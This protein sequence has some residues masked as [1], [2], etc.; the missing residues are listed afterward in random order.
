MTAD[1]TI[2]QG[3]ARRPW[4]GL[5][6]YVTGDGTRAYATEHDLVPGPR[7]SVELGPAEPVTDAFLRTLAGALGTEIPLEFLPET[8]LYRTSE[9][10]AWWVPAQR[11]TM[12]YAEHLKQLQPASGKLAPHPALVFVASRSRLWVRALKRSQRPTQDTRL[13][14][15]PYMN[16]YENGGVCLGSM[17]IP[18]SAG[19]AATAQWVDAFF[20]SSFTHLAGA[21][22]LST[23]PNGVGGLWNELAGSKKQFPVRYLAEAHQTLRTFVRSCQH[24]N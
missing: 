6:V 16:T 20:N 22:R 18:R 15:A 19:L 21:A 8:I 12:F 9:L 1:V 11:R 24:T 10:L 7:G 17:P 2:D 5:T 4:K 3:N 23:H 14:V 13:Q